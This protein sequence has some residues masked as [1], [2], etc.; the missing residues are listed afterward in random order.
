MFINDNGASNSIDSLEHRHY[1]GRCSREIRPLFPDN[2]IFLRSTRT[3]R[4]AHPFV[5]DC[6]VNR[7]MYY[8]EN[9]FKLRK[10]VN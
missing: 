3:F 8:R 6:P 4:R 5:V 10:F 1:N 7:K 2:Y 9:S